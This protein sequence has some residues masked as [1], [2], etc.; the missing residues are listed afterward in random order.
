MATRHLGTFIEKKKKNTPVVK[1]NHSDNQP[2]P[3]TIE[4][5]PI[6]IYMDA[7]FSGYC[8]GALSEMP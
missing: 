6:L 4:L 3:I 5:D 2:Y 8:L 7:C 1:Y